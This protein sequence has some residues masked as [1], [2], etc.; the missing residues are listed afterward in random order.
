MD[1]TDE[2]IKR[3]LIVRLC[4]LRIRLNALTEEEDEKY[5]RGHFLLDL[6]G[7]RA[8][9]VCQKKPKSQLIPPILSSSFSAP[10]PLL[11]CKFC[12]FSVHRNCS[13][14]LVSIS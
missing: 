5:T 6:N 3:Q 7:V 1:C 12:A 2:K 14:Y 13:V 8:C 4:E 11:Q 10:N 9:E